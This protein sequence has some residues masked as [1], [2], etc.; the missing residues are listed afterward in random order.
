MIGITPCNKGSQISQF[1]SIFKS[2][3][4]YISYLTESN[5][6]GEESIDNGVNHSVHL[7]VLNFIAV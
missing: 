7:G 6:D 3:K 4:F 5:E 2:T 1:C